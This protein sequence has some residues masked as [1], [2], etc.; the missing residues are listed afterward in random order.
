MRGRIEMGQKE[1]KRQRGLKPGG[2]ATVILKPEN[3]PYKIEIVPAGAMVR[4]KT[5]FLHLEKPK[6]DPHD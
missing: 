1:D 5:I 3:F 6:E 4:P 2:T